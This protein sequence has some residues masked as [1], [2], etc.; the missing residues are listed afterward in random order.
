MKRV[1]IG[2]RVL[3]FVVDTIIIALITWAVFRTWNWYVRYWGY[4][5][6]NFWLFFAAVLVVY[7]TFFETL[8]GRTPGKWLSYS[9]VINSTGKKPGFF[10]VLVRSITRLILIDFFFF[11]MADKTLHDITSKTEVVEV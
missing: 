3:N 2:T 9:R 10:M 4:P 5:Y 8:F 11:P 7:Y 6:F 1:G